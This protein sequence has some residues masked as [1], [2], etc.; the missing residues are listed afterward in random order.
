M[1]QRHSATT[2][3]G[4]TRGVR[5]P[6]RNGRQPRHG[7][8]GHPNVGTIAVRPRQVAPSSAWFGP[9]IEGSEERD[10]LAFLG[11]H[12]GVAVLQWP[13]DESHRACLAKFGLPRLLLVHPSTHPAPDPTE[14]EKVLP[15]SAA[16]DEIHRCLVELSRNAFR[17]RRSSGNPL[18]DDQGCLQAGSGSVE[19]QALE[20]S[21]GIQLLEHF[22][23]AVD[24]ESLLAVS[25]YSSA[26]TPAQLGGHLARLCQLVNPLGLEVAAALEGKH[27][28]RWCVA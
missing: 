10:L 11:S 8:Q 2:V 18:M 27:L 17:N 28:M 4:P 21:L 7:E 3:G 13:R 23:E 14:L 22:G 6:R 26:I 12:N 20:R 5:A 1:R 15:Y 24:D 19:L 9:A 16:A 25:G